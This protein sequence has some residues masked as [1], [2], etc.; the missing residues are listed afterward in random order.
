[1]L[2]SKRS[3]IIEV[4]LVL[5]ARQ[6]SAEYDYSES[7]EYHSEY[8]DDHTHPDY[9]KYFGGEASASAAVPNKQSPGSGFTSGFIPPA[10]FQSFWNIPI[11]FE[12]PKPKETAPQAQKADPFEALKQSF[13][14]K[15]EAAS[16]S[17]PLKKDY[18][19]ESQK[20]QQAES[21]EVK[22]GPYY[23][24]HKIPVPQVYE[25]NE[26]G[27]QS[28]DDVET[29]RPPVKK[30][31]K[32]KVSSD[33][34][35]YKDNFGGFETLRKAEEQVDQTKI[36][37]ATYYGGKTAD[38]NT[39][40]SSSTVSQYPAATGY[41]AQLQIPT[42]TVNPYQKYSYQPLSSKYLETLTNAPAEKPEG[43]GAVAPSQTENVKNKNCRKINGPE[44]AEDMNCFVC[45]D[46]SNKA[47]YTQC[48]YTSSQEPVNQ[49]AGSSIRY[50][51]PVK[52][53]EALRIKRSP[54]KPK[55]DR[56]PYYEVSQ[57]NRKYF[58]D[59]EKEQEVAESERQKDFHYKPYDPEEYESYSASQSSELLKKPGAC[60]KV[61][62][63]GGETCTVCKDETT[64]GN[65][66]QCSYTSAPKESKYAY[67]AEKK[68][69]SEQD[70]PEETKTVTKQSSEPQKTSATKSK[71]VVKDP[72][73][74]LSAAG[75]A[76]DETS[77]EAEEAE[78]EESSKEEKESEDDTPSYYNDEE[79][80][81][82]KKLVSDDPYDV[83]EHFAAT[84][85]D[86]KTAEEDDEEESFDE[87][88]Y[89]LFP[90]LNKQAESRQEEQ[91]TDATEK[92]Q[93]DVEEVLA[94]FAK[95][96]RSNCKKAE[97]NGMTCFLC[98]DQHKVQH[99]ECMYVAESKPKPTHIAY[100]EVQRLKDPKGE[101]QPLVN[102]EP[103]EESKK[104]ETLSAKPLDLTGENT[105]R[106]KFF[107][108]VPQELTGAAS[109]LYRTVVPYENQKKRYAKKFLRDSKASGSAPDSERLE[110][111]ESKEEEEETKEESK[112]EEPEAP[113]EVDVGEEE[114]AY[115]HETKPTYSKLF[116]TTLPKYMV[117]KTEFEKEFDAVS[118]FD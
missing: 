118:G 39:G 86:K 18:F 54:R 11:T 31:K 43:D 90:E 1:M 102:Q 100:H 78:E 115:S 80:K 109:D 101:H 72:I 60:T 114:G 116:D 65:F 61:E 5:I 83:P 97:K 62:R 106:K 41:L 16:E 21:S 25:N 15:E 49:Y 56:D 71:I 51:T 28:K 70:Q 38:Y 53:P 68:Y 32:P 12:D 58:E 64:G 67:V 74:E 73:P 7:D 22:P 81:K 35:D 98:V 66:E 40:K 33:F 85:T 104:V 8:S 6:G 94:E 29:I 89:K 57:R 113:K 84:V 37:P 34:D 47:K 52:A 50:S 110:E 117:E 44:N 26:E 112:E 103:S 99:E 9:T 45:E 92:K 36:D 76:I 4:C 111:S 10:E 30:S 75:T 105:K 107:K 96:D 23:V 13:A 14:Q 95:K 46:A 24:S 20:R 77:A 42:T 2:L 55:Y 59:F 79:L 17:N 93:H 3:I 48:S 91:K 87:Y 19:E 88:H 69:D 63:E 27:A 108:K 82:D